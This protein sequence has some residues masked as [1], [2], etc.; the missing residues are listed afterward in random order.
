MLLGKIFKN[1]KIIIRTFKKR[2]F[3]VETAG[4]IFAII[5]TAALIFCIGFF[6]QPGKSSKTHMP[7]TIAKYNY[8]DDKTDF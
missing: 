1:M 8:N 5:A 7:T 3:I 4:P 2:N 6:M